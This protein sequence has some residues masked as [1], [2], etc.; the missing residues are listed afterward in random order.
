MFSSSI[1]LI[2]LNLKYYFLANVVLEYLIVGKPDQF[3]SCIM[4]SNGMLDLV[5]S[6]T[7]GLSET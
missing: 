4:K 3:V 5:T 1:K 6:M 2:H 7:Y